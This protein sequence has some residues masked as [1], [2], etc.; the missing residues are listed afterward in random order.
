MILDQSQFTERQQLAWKWALTTSKNLFISGFAGTGKTALIHRIKMDLEEKGRIVRTVTF[1]GQAAQ[2]L[3]GTTVSRLLG[4]RLAKSLQ[5]SGEVHEEEAQENLKGVTD[6]ILD[7]VSMCSGDFL[8]L[9]DS[10]LQKVKGTKKT[11]GG[12]RMIFSGDF[13]QLPPVHTHQDPPLR[14]KWAFEYPGF[15]RCHGIFLNESMRQR[16]P[17]DVRLLNEF[18][19][20]IISEE[21][22][23]FLNDAINRPL[24]VPAELYGLRRDADEVNQLKLNLTSGLLKRYGTIFNPKRFEETFLKQIPIGRY[25]DLKEGIPTIILS[26]DPDGNYTN[27]NQG[28]VEHMGFDT[29][30]IRLPS[31]KVVNIGYKTWQIYGKKRCQLG[32]V[33]GIPL[34]LGWAATIHRAQGLTLNEVRADITR[35]WEPGQAYVALSRTPSLQNFSLVGPVKSIK[36]SSEVLEFVRQLERNTT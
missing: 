3:G 22:R 29:I 30:D 21:G 4:L 12:I 34:Q 27:G 8:E 23:K 26:N 35:L 15:I 6:I 36:V 17:Q 31:D 13:L 33:E 25:L 10:I 1:T 28:I 24:K 7:E 18:R 32:E 20:G 19:Q 2:K 11:F 9:V 16:D 5:E 14:R